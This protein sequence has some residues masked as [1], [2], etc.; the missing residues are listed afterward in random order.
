[1]RD[2]KKTIREV[3]GEC[4]TTGHA[5]ELA[6]AMLDALTSLRTI[7]SVNAETN[8]P[9][10]KSCA[11]IAAATLAKWDP[12]FDA[13]RNRS[14]GDDPISRNEEKNPVQTGKKSR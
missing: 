7:A 5:R 2:I 14:A 9:L 12:G 13:S 10:Q 1:M 3:L 8:E 6:M 11:L 4:S